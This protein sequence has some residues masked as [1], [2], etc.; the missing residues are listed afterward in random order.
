MVAVFL[1]IFGYGALFG[2]VVRRR[3]PRGGVPVTA[4]ALKSVVLGEGSDLRTFSAK[5]IL[6]MPRVVPYDAFAIWLH[7][8]RAPR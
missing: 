3:L 2:M 5:E 8:T 7:A 4:A 6:A 1:A